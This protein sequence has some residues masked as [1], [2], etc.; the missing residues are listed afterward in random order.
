MLICKAGFPLGGILHAELRGAEFFFVFS[1]VPPEKSQDK[2][3]FRSSCKIPPNENRLKGAI[4][5]LTQ[6]SSLRVHA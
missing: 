1:L 2:E 6:S 5:V 3:K 4:P